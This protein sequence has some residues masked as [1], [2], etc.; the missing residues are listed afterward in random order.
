MSEGDGF[1]VELPPPG[2]NDSSPEIVSTALQQQ[3]LNDTM[4]GSETNSDNMPLSKLL[5]RVAKAA[6]KSE[7]DRFDRGVEKDSSDATEMKPKSRLQFKLPTQKR[8]AVEAIK[9]KKPPKRA[10]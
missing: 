1:V 3:G 7:G 6:D 10:A 4:I 9:P 5:S 8:T 2:L